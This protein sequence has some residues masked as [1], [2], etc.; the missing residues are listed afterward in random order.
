MATGKHSSSEITITVDDGAGSPQAITSYVMTMGAMKIT[1]GMTPTTA[2][3]V[4]WETHL[5][6]GLKKVEPFSLSGFWDDTATTSP[7]VV[8]V[9]PD[10]TPSTASRTVTIVFGNSKTFAGEA[11]LTGYSVIGKAGNL[12]E[13]AAD[14]QPTGTWAWS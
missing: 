1:A 12:T 7:H 14:F 2:F 11:F 8:L 9:A 3:G 13:F 6:T 5:P 10:S 4:A